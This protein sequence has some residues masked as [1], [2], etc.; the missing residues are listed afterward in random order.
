MRITKATLTAA[1]IVTLPQAAHAADRQVY[2]IPPG[3]LGDALVLLGRQAGITIGAVDPGVPTARCKGLHGAFTVEKAVR[4]LLS[5]TAFDYEA[6]DATTIRVF[7]RQ[8]RTEPL[9]VLRPRPDLPSPTAPAVPDIVVTASKR[10]VALG[11]FAATLNMITLDPPGGADRSALGTSAVLSQ[12]PVLFSTNLGP[13]RNKLFIRG[14]ADSSFTGPT[15]STVGQYLGDVRL[16]YNA[17][18]PDLN[19]YDI[20]HIE[21]IMGPQGTLYGAGSLGGI[22]RLVPNPPRLDRD[23]VSAAAGITLT[24]HGEPGYDL[25]AMGNLDL[26]PGRVALRLIAYRSIDGGYIDDIGRNAKNVNRTGIVGGRATLRIDAGDDWTVDLG[27]VLQNLNSRDGQYA[28]RGLP[29]LTRSTAIEQPF[30]NDFMLWQA[31]VRKRWSKIELVSA[32]GVVRHDVGVRY[33][34]TGFPGTTGPAAFDESSRIALITHETRLSRSNSGG[35][36]WVI[37]GS[38]VSDANRIRRA[39]GDPDQPTVIAGVRNEVSEAALFGEGTIAILPHVNATLGGRITYAHVSGEPLGLSIP[40][41]SEPRRN[42]FRALPTAALSWKALPRLLLFLRYQEGFRAGGLSVSQTVPITAQRFRAD[43]ISTI[44]AGMRLGTPRV[45][46]LT[47]SA[48]ISYANWENIQAD[49]IDISGLPFTANVGDGRIYG[50]EATLGWMPVRGLVAELAT[51]INDSE[52]SKPAP[53]FGKRAE[54][55]P[56]IP[57]AGVRGS[58][59]YTAQLKGGF[60]LAGEVAAQYVGRSRLGA[61]PF[62]DLE[63]GDY[64]DVSAGIRLDSSRWGVTLDVANALETMGNRFSL[65]NPISVTLGNEITPLRP[66]SIRIGFHAGF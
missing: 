19:L 52:L 26:V 33:D 32:T 53:D 63:Q 13:G 18:D 55:L 38:F 35:S 64:V 58:F 37:G 16:T 40:R 59:G 51:F 28:E 47:A 66:R 45:D 31:V 3:T 43:T 2:A 23:E 9:A 60:T 57:R 48:S 7:R 54:E 8:T 4:K 61:G 29:P 20:N 50:I 22:F 6:I 14:V 17:P 56:N 62:L 1:L 21:V 25:A 24:Q 11:D 42:E 44:E 30:D 12:L 36:G 65:G 49:L 10:N 5:D 27:A 34:A 39:I 46:R 41:A 15:Q